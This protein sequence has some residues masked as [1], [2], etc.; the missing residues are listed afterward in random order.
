MAWELTRP[1]GPRHTVL[2]SIALEHLEIFRAVVRQ[3]SFSRA[4][5]E[6]HLSQ[7]A[8]SQ[9]I[10]YLES[11]LGVLLF[12]RQRGT[13]VRLTAAGAH[14]L[15]FANEVL[16]ATERLLRRLDEIKR[17]IEGEVLDVAGSAG[18]IRYRLLRPVAELR[19]RFPG[20]VVRLHQVS[21]AAERDLGLREGRFTLGLYS[22]PVPR[23]QF[24]AF[25]LRPDRLLLCAAPGHRITR[26]PTAV[27]MEILRTTPFALFNQ[28][29]SNRALVDRW[30]RAHRLC[31]IPALESATI[32]T[33]KE[34]VLQ[35]FALAILP[36]YAIAD[37][38]AAGMIE[39]VEADG[40]PIRRRLSL[41]AD[42]SRPLPPV[43][44]IFATMVVA[45]HQ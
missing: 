24:I 27:R 12:D 41:V 18:F 4:A 11:V 15:E 40:L 14:F 32:D 19:R 35:G 38:V 44:R 43:A 30:A 10:R 23:N 26:A 45:D 29:S 9:R 21:T 33:L 5:V 2:A 34:A 17:P 1:A 6:M 25:P 28:G 13:A 39:V 7:P 37:E 20:L 22:G 16:S 42:S 3:G 36:E 31:L 8:V